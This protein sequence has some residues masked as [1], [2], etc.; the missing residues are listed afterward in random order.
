MREPAIKYYCISKETPMPYEVL[1][2]VKGD[3]IRHIEQLWDEIHKLKER[4]RKLE[5]EL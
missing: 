1:C 3:P 2:K 5:N 4:L